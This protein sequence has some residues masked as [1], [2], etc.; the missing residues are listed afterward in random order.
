MVT[1]AHAHF[2]DHQQNFLTSLLT[3]FT[4]SSLLNCKDVQ[5]IQVVLDGLNNMLKLAFPEVTSIDVRWL[6]FNTRRIY[7]H[8][9]AA[10][11][12]G[13]DN[14]GARNKVYK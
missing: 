13:N 10:A 8:A 12:K 4:S 14:D 5:V 7:Y 3:L 6:L 2:E 11:I 9:A 1:V